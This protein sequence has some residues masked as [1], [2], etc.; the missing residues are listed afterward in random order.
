MELKNKI[1]MEQFINNYFDGIEDDEVI[2]IRRIGHTIENDNAT[3]SNVMDLL[4]YDKVKYKNTYFCLS[5][6][7]N[8]AENYKT[9]NVAYRYAIAFDWD[10]KD[11]LNCSKEDLYKL[12]NEDRALF[13][14]NKK[15][16]L[17]DIY[18]RV[19][20]IGGLVLHYIIDSGYGYHAYILINKS[21]EI[22]KIE[23]VQKALIDLLDSDTQCKD[24]VRVLRVP[25]TFNTK[26]GIIGTNIV[27]NTIGNSNFSRYDIDRLYNRF[28][29]SN[30]K[31]EE[32]KYQYGFD[33]EL[34]S[35]YICIEN[36]LKNGSQQHHKNDDLVNIVVYY[37]KKNYSL[38]E[39]QNIVKEWDTKSNYN[40]MTEYRV[41]YIYNNQNSYDFKCDGCRHSGECKRRV[42]VEF[43]HS[44]EYGT[45]VIEDKY[46]KLCKK[47]KT[48]KQ[49]E[50][51][52]RGD[53]VN[54]I[55]INELSG[56]ELLLINML[57]YHG[58]MN[59]SKFTKELTYTKKKKVKNVAMNEKTFIKTTKL[60]EE[61]GIVEII[62]GN[63]RA[64][65]E[66]SYR[67]KDIKAKVENTIE[68]GYMVNIFA[69]IGAI[70]P[71]ELKLYH[72]MRYIQKEQQRESN[73]V[74]SGALLRI[75]QSELAQWYYGSDNANYKGNISE[76]IEGLIESKLLEIWSID[77]DDKGRD[78]YTYK[79]VK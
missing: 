65:I 30:S 47:A 72:L 20:A 33:T 61:K 18:K 74:Y 37:K 59:K 70:S 73:N 54:K 22:E 15:L 27:S 21:N 32:V 66:N 52:G 25:Y 53:K 67:L 64:G 2:N 28:C 35:T 9:E 36:A 45:I 50:V 77:K 62:K 57:K 12:H 13:D 69:I 46:S 58:Q 43:N 40:D 16:L 51:K 17:T 23:K 29:L 63:S 10:L 6:F 26:N 49:K 1:Q 78:Y 75:N 19:N 31:Y 60:L 24:M 79:M 56:N 3:L 5:T 42:K 34:K 8:G 38:E 44:D 39:V 48:K 71:S 7:N 76:M 4:E 14:R 41:N 55:I 11:Y 68:V